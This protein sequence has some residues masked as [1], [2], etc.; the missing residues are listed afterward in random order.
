MHDLIND[1]F[2][3]YLI[4]YHYYIHK[5]TETRLH[6]MQSEIHML[7]WANVQKMT[8]CQ[9]LTITTDVHGHKHNLDSLALV[10]PPSMRMLTNTP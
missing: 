7:E 10:V 3:N 4:S 8:V 5:H 9:T 2:F 1:L 6:R